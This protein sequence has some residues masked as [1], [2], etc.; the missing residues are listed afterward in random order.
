M[1]NN[2]YKNHI[3]NTITFTLLEDL[4]DKQSA[5]YLTNIIKLNRKI[6]LQD[7]IKWLKYM[8]LEKGWKVTQQILLLSAEL[9]VI[10]KDELDTATI[11]EQDHE[12]VDELL[13]EIVLA[14]MRKETQYF[15]KI[16]HK[17]RK[18]KR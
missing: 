11:L 15:Q 10:E 18:D 7:E 4:R 16:I 9:L 8:E 5:F 17:E 14:N 6:K 1:K 12:T 2:D 13:L 3:D